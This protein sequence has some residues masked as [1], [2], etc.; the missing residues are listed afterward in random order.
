MMTGEYESYNAGVNRPQDPDND[1]RVKAEVR[2][3]KPSSWYYETVPAKHVFP[4]RVQQDEINLVQ[5]SEDA[6]TGYRERTA[7]VSSEEWPEY[8]RQVTPPGVAAEVAVGLAQDMDAENL[9]VTLT[10][11]MG[12]LRSRSREDGR[13][14]G[15]DSGWE[16]GVA[17]ATPSVTEDSGECA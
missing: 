16:A 4:G 2:K 5:W 15:F 3:T 7:V 14:A 9:H 10:A 13:L 12:L 8:V 6:G 1:P 11:M 17:Y